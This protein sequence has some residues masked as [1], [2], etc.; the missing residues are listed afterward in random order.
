MRHSAR[1]FVC[2]LLAATAVAADPAIEQLMRA[3]HTRRA[4]PLIEAALKKNSSDSAALIY[5]ARMK[6][7]EGD[8]DGAEKLAQSAVKANPQDAVAHFW[9]ARILAEKA[10]KASIF[11]QLGLA[12][13]CKRELEEAL[14]LDPNSVEANYMLAMYLLQAPGIA[15]GDKDRAK[16]QA[17]VVA[18]LDPAQG[19]LLQA[20]MANHEKNTADLAGLYQKAHDAAPND[21]AAQVPW[22]NYLS[23]QKRF[24]EAEKCSRALVKLD[25]GRISGYNGL[26]YI[27][28]V[29]SRWKEL[30]A[31]LVEA[32]KAVPDNLTPHFQV[33]AVIANGVG[34]SNDYAR[35]ERSL[36]KYLSMDPEPGGTKASRAH[37]RL[38]QVLEKA[39]RKP[40]AVQEIRTAAK[41][42][43]DY[44][45]I[46]EELKRLG[47]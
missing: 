46:Q 34:G 21:Y 30:D 8:A 23:G 17:Q 19:Y 20:E 3:G 43:P 33:G 22:C 40:E 15:G 11:S 38:A 27:Y 10:Q 12:R 28:T 14:R 35:A 18:K 13:S 24:D 25:P 6:R 32:E 44:K 29:Q 5:M 37:W 39:G 42:E 4:R 2:L 26:A 9:L 7:V 31:V 1:L 36:R 41:L 16:Q 47:G 45:P